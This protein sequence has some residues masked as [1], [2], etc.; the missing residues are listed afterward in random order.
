MS[1]DS[2]AL[3]LFFSLL[4]FNFCPLPSSLFVPYLVLSFSKYSWKFSQFEV[5]IQVT[6][7][8]IMTTFNIKVN[9][10]LALIEYQ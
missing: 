2:T 9:I 3:P 6:A 7:I 5:I 10:L 1:P 8:K 4:L